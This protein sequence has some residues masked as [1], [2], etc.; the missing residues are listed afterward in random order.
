MS[1]RAELALFAHVAARPE[2]ELD[3]AQAA[4]V[5]AEAEYPALDIARFI[6]RL[7][8]LGAGARRWAEGARTVEDRL[9][10]V[11]RF[12]YESERFH[13]NDRD[14]YD[15]RNSF[16]NDVLER[17]TGIPITL[18]VVLVEV[19]RRAGVEARGVSFP[20]HFL[21][22][23]TTTRGALL[24]DPFDGRLLGRAELRALYERATGEARDPDAA[25]L[26]PAT[27]RQI[28]VRML[29]NLRGIYAARGDEAR[30][31]G[32]VARLELL[33]PAPGERPRRGAN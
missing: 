8:E 12:L 16:L 17:R 25:L 3:L 19:C 11:V 20:G 5:I 21:V 7:D 27:K 22:R 29:N 9:A 6:E 13:G 32:V 4:L 30:L 31:G 24:V 26:E 18:A 2:K 10:C 15:P 14:Y 33:E 23:V 28:L 1:G